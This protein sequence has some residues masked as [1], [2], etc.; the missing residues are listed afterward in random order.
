[1]RVI[2]WGINYPPEETGIAPYNVALCEFLRRR[3][4]D[5]EMVT[6]FAYYPMWRKQDEDRRRLS[7][8]DHING[9]PIRPC[10]SSSGA[11]TTR[12]RRPALPR[13]TSRS[14]NFCAGEA[15]TS[16]W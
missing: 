8:T 11:L 7:R 14:V 5:V 6:T 15:T 3:G 13:T 10:V 2:V 9:V 12:R 4:D 1:M 16:R